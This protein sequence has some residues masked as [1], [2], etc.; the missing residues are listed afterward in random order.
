MKKINNIVKGISGE[1]KA[2]KYLKKKKYTI[3]EHNV[4]FKIG[5]VDIIARRNDTIVFVE[6]KWRKDESYGKP[7]ESVDY[8]KQKKYI[9]MAKMYMVKNRLSGFN[10]RFDIIEITGNNINHIENAFEE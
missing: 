7:S 5:E 6:V 10:F 1:N 3:L 8:Y 4:D 9:S 2:I